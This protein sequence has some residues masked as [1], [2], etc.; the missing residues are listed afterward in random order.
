ML[1]NQLLNEIDFIIKHNELLTEH[2]IKSKA[3]QIL[4]KYKQGI[5]IDE[6]VIN[7]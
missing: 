1:T 5:N 7:E 4:M 3:R 6:H 2:T